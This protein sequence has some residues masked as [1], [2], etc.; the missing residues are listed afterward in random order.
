METIH[1]QKINIF[2]DSKVG[3]SSLIECMDKYNDDNFKIEADLN[4]SSRNDSFKASSIYIEQ[5][6]K[7]QFNINENRKVYYNIYE[8]SMNSYNEM[9]KQRMDEENKSNKA[10][11]ILTQPKEEN[12]LI[13]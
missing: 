2:G 12:I 10:V 13:K 11:E 9:L 8:T 5:I 3:K 7:I 6:R 4:K 1:F